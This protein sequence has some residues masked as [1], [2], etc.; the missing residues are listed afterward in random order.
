MKRPLTLSAFITGTSLFGLFTF[1]YLIQSIAFGAFDLTELM[2]I[3]IILT[4]F[5]IACLVLNACSISVYNKSHEE[6][7]KKK[8]LIIASIVLNF[9]EMLFVIILMAI[10]STATTII[11]NL[12]F[13]LALIAVNVL[14]IVDL[15]MENKKYEQAKVEMAKLAEPTPAPATQPKVVAKKAK[16]L[17]EE[18]E[19]KEELQ[20][21][22]D[23]L[24]RM[25][26]SGLITEEEYFKFKQNLIQ[27]YLD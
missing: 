19:M 12:L 13:L 18:F 17:D 15:S 1:V 7:M 11:F 4:A 5:T 16:T 10:A 3:S 24:E 20:N 6:Y 21:K 27:K 25:K 2:I 26:K 9:T 23:K 14:A 22:I 8:S